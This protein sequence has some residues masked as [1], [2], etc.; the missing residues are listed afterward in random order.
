MQIKNRVNEKI[1][2][3]AFGGGEGVTRLNNLVVSLL[4]RPAI[5]LEWK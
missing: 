3:I 2:S 4:R 5:E 1:K